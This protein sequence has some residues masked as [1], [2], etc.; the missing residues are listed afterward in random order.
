[1]QSRGDIVA[2]IGPLGNGFALKKAEGKNISDGRRYRYSADAG[3]CKTVECEENRLFF[4]Y[5]DELFLKE[6]L[7]N[8]E[9]YIATEDGSSGTKGNVM[10][11]IRE[12]SL[13][14]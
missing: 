8:T 11:A 10:D 7:S 4:G 13:D 2:V 14:G 9:L 3:T 12:K 5:R 6:N 1:M